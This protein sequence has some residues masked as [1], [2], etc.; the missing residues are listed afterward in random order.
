MGRSIQGLIS[1]IIVHFVWYPFVYA[2]VD[3]IDLRFPR[4]IFMR[5][6]VDIVGINSVVHVG[7]DVRIHGRHTSLIVVVRYKAGVVVNVR[8]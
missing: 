3:G 5:R 1:C 2:L 4:V 6:Q 8:I 7:Q